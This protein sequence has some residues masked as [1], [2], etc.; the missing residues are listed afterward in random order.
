MR[1]VP[2]SHSSTSALLLSPLIYLGSTPGYSARICQSSSAIRCILKVT[3]GLAIPRNTRRQVLAASP[4]RSRTSRRLEQNRPLAHW[5]YVKVHRDVGECHPE[6]RPQVTGST[7]CIVLKS[8]KPSRIRPAGSPSST[9][10][11]P[12]QNSP[13]RST[14]SDHR[15][16]HRPQPPEGLAKSA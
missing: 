9:W 3:R 12:G 6:N 4:N 2:C 10:R 16:R 5:E 7:R 13:S 15:M 8:P 1:R 11:K 14:K